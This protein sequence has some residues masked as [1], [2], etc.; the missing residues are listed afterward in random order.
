MGNVLA[1]N[2]P[3]CMA[4]GLVMIFVGYTLNIRWVMEVMYS[5]VIFVQQRLSQ[6]KWNI[7]FNKKK[8]TNI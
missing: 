8:S 4:S 2:P 1:I 5:S 6:I 3:V 7:Y